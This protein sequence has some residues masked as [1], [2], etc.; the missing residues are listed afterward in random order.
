MGGRVLL[1]LYFLHSY[2][3]QEFD[4]SVHIFQLSYQKNNKDETVFL[5]KM[6]QKFLISFHSA[7]I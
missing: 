1:Y 5:D 4:A 7:L 2:Q 6:A 3:M